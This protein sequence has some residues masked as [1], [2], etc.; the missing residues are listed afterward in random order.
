MTVVS[1]TP[2]P[3][4]IIKAPIVHSLVGSLDLVATEVK[5]PPPQRC[6]RD[7]LSPHI[8]RQLGVVLT[9]TPFGVEL[10]SITRSI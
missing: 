6:S 1:Y 7:V 2:K 3:I 5:S 10:F 8:G 4:L 9:K